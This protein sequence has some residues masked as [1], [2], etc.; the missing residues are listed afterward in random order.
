MSASETI[1]EEIGGV[2]GVS[3]QKHDVHHFRANRPVLPDDDDDISGDDAHDER[4]R[5]AHAHGGGS[6]QTADHGRQNQLPVGGGS[7]ELPYYRPIAEDDDAERNDADG[8]EVDPRPTTDD[9][10]DVTWIQR[11]RDSP[12]GHVIDKRRE[13]D[14]NV[15]VFHKRE[16]QQRRA[17]RA[18]AARRAHA[19]LPEREADGDVALG[20]E[21]DDRPDG[22]VRQRVMRRPDDATRPHVSLVESRAPRDPRVERHRGY[23]QHAAVGDGEHRQVDVGRRPRQ[24]LAPQHQQHERV[25]DQPREAQHRP[26]APPHVGQLTVVQPCRDDR[27]V[28]RVGLSQVSRRRRP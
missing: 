21:R 4:K 24:S 16:R 15:G 28:P 19:Q 13:N 25:A 11:T 22:G 14:E 12:V 1:E 2:I 6:R 5:D 17:A 8:D 9:V 26:H 27:V 3:Q 23:D 20:R 7:P 10:A 18:G